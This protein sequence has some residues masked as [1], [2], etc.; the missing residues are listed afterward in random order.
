MS[1][2]PKIIELGMSDLEDILRRVDAKELCEEDYA[3]IRAVF[4]SYVGLYHAV[5]DKAATIAR[6]R[7]LVFGIKTEKT[8]AVLG[9][10]TADDVATAEAASEES[11]E[12]PDAKES[13]KEK[14]PAQ[15]HGRNSAVKY[16]GAEK[17]E[18]SHPTLQP[19]DKCPECQK[20]TVYEAKPKVLV[21][22]IGQPPV[23]GKVYYLQKLRCG[24]C[25]QIFTATQPEAAGEKK[26]SVAT[27]G[28]PRV[29][30]SLPWPKPRCPT[31][32]KIRKRPSGPGCS[33]R[34]SSR[35]AT[36]AESPC[37]SRVTSTRA[38]T[39]LMCCRIEPL[40]WPSRSRCVMHY[41]KTFLPNYKRFL[42]IA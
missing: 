26:L 25:G 17:I 4:E 8:S 23:G 15:G 3:T 36:V 40:S 11:Q 13:A 28:L 20:G 21:R 18:V 12:T 39:C 22:L 2:K 38:K 37:S 41:R 7:K 10:S 29:P 34:A 5:G 32:R 9:T 33:R 6:L 16:T 1:T 27:S 42:Q 35:L 19:G 14:E 30:N 24:L 31:I